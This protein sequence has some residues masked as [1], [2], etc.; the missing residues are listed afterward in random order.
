M[1]SDGQTF[2]YNLPTPVTLLAGETRVRNR[3]ALA[4]GKEDLQPYVNADVRMRTATWCVLGLRFRLTD[5]QRVPMPICTMHKMHR[6]RSTH[7]LLEKSS[8][9][10]LQAAAF[11]PQYFRQGPQAAYGR[12]RDRGIGTTEQCRGRGSSESEI[13]TPSW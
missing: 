9:L 11:H 2:L 10:R 1:G 7:D 13:V 8:M 6:L 5:D 4:I 12:I 3:V